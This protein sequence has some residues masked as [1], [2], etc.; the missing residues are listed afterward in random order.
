L[1][2]FRFSPGSNTADRIH[3]REWSQAAF[4]EAVTTDKLI[5]VFVVAFWCGVCQRLDEAALSS[6]EVQLL[7]NAYFV[8][9]RVEESRRPDV[10]LR[11]AQEGWP[12]IAFLTP[13]GEPILTVN[14]L[15]SEQ[16]T[17]LLVHLVDA[18][19]HHSAE[20]ADGPSTGEPDSNT[21]PA[22]RPL[23]GSRANPP[24][25]AASAGVL[26]E[27]SVG[28]IVQL[29]DELADHRD[30]GFGRPHK[31]F[32]ADALEFYLYLSQR[33]E[34]FLDHVDL[35]LRT[36]IDRSIYDVSDGGFFRYSSKPDW[37]EPHR[38]KLLVDQADL[39]RIYLETFQCTYDVTHQR[40]AERLIDY[41]EQTLRLPHTP[42]LAG[43]QDFVRTPGGDWT[44]VIDPLV[45]C[46]ANAHAVSAYLQAWTVLGRADCRDRALEL[47]DELWE[48]F[49][50]ETGGVQHYFDG[51]S[52]H[53]PGLLNDSVALGRALLDVYMSVNNE[54][55]LERAALLGSEIPRLHLNP[56][57]GFFDISQPGPAA[58]QRPV[59]ELTQNAAAAI[60]FLRLSELRGDPRLRDAARW[61]LLGYG[62][63]AQV[64]GAYAA[65]FAHALD[66]YLA[67]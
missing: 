43:C 13:R 53:V 20:S 9:I 7:L 55:Y 41:M 1:P 36:L 42:L 44:P 32:Y 63:S 39:L 21:V 18:H 3:W 46:D 14:A 25:P 34:R 64:Y 24:G 33:D 60:F 38:E 6:D 35:T 27:S 15:E 23:S 16:L 58:L 50:V 40:V 22:G 19:E 57:G 56:E 51:E 12:T 2:A 52:A 29:L 11:Y 8:P 45:Y 59:T 37:N 49:K 48:T 62:G 47:V 5:A 67:S 4:D 26:S 54:R 31:Y 28:E 61:A 10:D 65:S 30:G 66:R 17:S